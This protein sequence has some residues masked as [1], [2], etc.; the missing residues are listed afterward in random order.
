RKLVRLKGG[1]PAI[2]GRLGE[3]IAALQHAC[4]P[5]AI[6]PGITAASAAAAASGIS[7]S[8]RGRARRVQFVAA[9]ARH[10]EELELDWPALADNSATT[11]FYM[12]RESAS[13]IAERLISHGLSASTPVLLMSDVSHTTEMRMCVALSGLADAVENFPPAVPLIILIGEVT[14]GAATHAHRVGAFSQAL[15]LHP[16]CA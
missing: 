11:V 15:A 10:G 13:L 3:E 7:L 9:H 1:D 5:F 6:V 8:L 4:I 14:E 2:F 12:A 16:A